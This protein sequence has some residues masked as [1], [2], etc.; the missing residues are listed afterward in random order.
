M[1]SIEKPK[2][3]IWKS[4]ELKRVSEWANFSL[5]CQES[6]IQLILADDRQIEWNNSVHTDEIDCEIR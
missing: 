5:K 4:N 1:V 3:K 6:S 2:L